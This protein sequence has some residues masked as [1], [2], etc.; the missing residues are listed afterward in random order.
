MNCF[1]EAKMKNTGKIILGGAITGILNGLFGSGGGVAAVLILKK[2]FKCEPKEAHATA[3][4]IILPLSVTSIIIYF[5]KS[6]IPVQTAI[7]TSIGGI[8]G[9][10]VGAKLLKKIKSQSLTR[11]FGIVMITGAIR[12]LMQ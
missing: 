6:N 5:L 2:L 10:L 9:G 12:M 1:Q 11:I 8:I 4:M 7:F 3:I